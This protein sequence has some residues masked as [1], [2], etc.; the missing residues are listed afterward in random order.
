M[1]RHG[2]P[3]FLVHI[4]SLGYVGVEV[5]AGEDELRASQID[6]FAVLEQIGLRVFV[7]HPRQPDRLVPWRKVL[8]K[9][10]ASEK[11]RTEKRLSRMLRGV[12][13]PERASPQ[14]F[15]KAGPVKSREGQST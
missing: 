15:L 3:D 11:A 1:W 7:W 9:Q 6:T 8:A 12:S 2:W 4:E 14:S 5:K 10:K 13:N